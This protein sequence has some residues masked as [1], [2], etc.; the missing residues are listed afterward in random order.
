MKVLKSQITN[1]QTKLNII[2]INIGKIVDK[3]EVYAILQQ[4]TQ[5]TGCGLDAIAGGCV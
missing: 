4:E 3:T 1:K 2:M 5:Y